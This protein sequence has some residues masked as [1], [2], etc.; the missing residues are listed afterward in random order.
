MGICRPFCWLRTLGNPSVPF[1]GSHGSYRPMKLN[2]LW[3]DYLP[4]ISDPTEAKRLDRPTPV[5]KTSAPERSTGPAVFITTFFG[6]NTL[7]A[8]E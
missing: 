6:A 2:S 3:S 5:Q 8:H 4:E 7:L 1:V